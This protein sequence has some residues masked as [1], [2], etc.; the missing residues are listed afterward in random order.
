MPLPPLPP[1]S[2]H[3]MTNL[4]GLE[5]EGIISRAISLEDNWR[6]E[7]PK[8]YRMCGLQTGRTILDMVLTPGGHY[9]LAS[10][11]RAGRHMLIL[12]GMDHSPKSLAEP[13]AKLGLG[14][15]RPESLCV[16]YMPYLGKQGIM[17]SYLKRPIPSSTR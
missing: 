11:L 3:D 17:I 12:Y 10:T 16:K 8:P 7:Q 5:A 9:L 1:T 14:P 4:T 6:C 2:K 13:V 15:R